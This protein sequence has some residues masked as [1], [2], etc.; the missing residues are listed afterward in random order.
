MA[1]NS[2]PPHLIPMEIRKE[3]RNMGQKD[4]KQGGQMVE[5][6]GGCRE[7][8]LLGRTSF[9]T[10][11]PCCESRGGSESPALVAQ[12]GSRN[13]SRRRCRDT[14]LGDYPCLEMPLFSFV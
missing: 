6:A 14:C 9:L 11:G 7:L 13:G 12:S 1:L 10:L 3:G 2:Q 4:C 8:H 5:A